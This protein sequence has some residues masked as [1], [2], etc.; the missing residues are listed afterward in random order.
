MDTCKRV[1]AQNWSTSQQM[2]ARKTCARS[3]TAAR[4]E[5][6]FVARDLRPETRPTLRARCG[7]CR[8]ISRHIPFFFFFF[9][10]RLIVR[11]IDAMKELCE[12]NA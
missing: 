3:V 12:C 2:N 9:S 5:V 8:L 7:N 11:T 4:Q 10:S 6:G 1:R